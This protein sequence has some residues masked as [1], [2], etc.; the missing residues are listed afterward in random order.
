MKPTSAI[1]ITILTSG[2]LFAQNPG[3]EPVKFYRASDRIDVPV[4]EVVVEEKNENL[5]EPKFRA[6][7]V[8]N[9]KQKQEPAEPMP[10]NPKHKAQTEL[11]APKKDD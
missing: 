2:S 7:T 6:S 11:S 4:R 9:E 10:A 5:N 8:L 1:L 3:G